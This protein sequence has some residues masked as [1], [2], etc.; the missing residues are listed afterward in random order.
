MGSSFLIRGIGCI[1]MLFPHRPTVK[2]FQGSTTS[3]HVG[4]APEPDKAV[5]V[6]KISE[7]PYDLHSYCFLG[8]DEFSVEQLDQNIACSR[9]KG[10]LP[11]LHDRRPSLSCTR[12]LRSS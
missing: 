11:E 5:R 4:K 1:A 10:V 9:M 6:I 8:F 7:L 12:S 2:G 3:W